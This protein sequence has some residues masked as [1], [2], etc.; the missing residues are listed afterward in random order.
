[1]KQQM[2]QIRPARLDD[3]EALAT[4]HVRS[5]QAAYVGLIP[6]DYLVNLSVARRAEVWN[7]IL[8]ASEWPSSGTLV[9]ELDGKVVAFVSIFPARDDDS[10]SSKV[11][12]VG[13]IYAVREVWG[14][15]IGRALMKAAISRLADAGY[16]SAT[17]WVLDTNTRA[18]RFYEAASWRPDGATK[19]DDRGEFALREVRY[20]CEISPAAP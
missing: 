14:R 11:G 15:G 17:L 20:R 10:D 19:R 18:R 16:S 8:A 4:V 1:M 9:A 13:S 3:A 6:Q 12:E 2:P 7:R 5:W